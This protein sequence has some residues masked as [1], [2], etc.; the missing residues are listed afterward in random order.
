MPGALGSASLNDRSQRLG[1]WSSRARA[2]APLSS[3]VF[4]R[5]V[6]KAHFKDKIGKAAEVPTVVE[7]TV[8]PI[9]TSLSSFL[10]LG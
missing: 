10:T 7:S 3:G 4:N 5:S 8:T 9:F 2:A 6:C 1:A